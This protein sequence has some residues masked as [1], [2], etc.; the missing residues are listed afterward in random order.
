MSCRRPV[1]FLIKWPQL[2]TYLL[3]DRGYASYKFRKILQQHKCIPV[4]PSKRR[5]FPCYCPQWAYRNRH[6]V[7][8]LWARL[9]EWRALA[10]HYDKTASSFISVLYIAALV[11]YLKS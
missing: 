6:V 8:S 3:C 1:T 2:P 5:Q 7:E 9:K 10:T 4:I 11:D